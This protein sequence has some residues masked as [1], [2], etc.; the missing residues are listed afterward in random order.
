MLKGPKYLF[1][2]VK[3]RI[4]GSSNLTGVDCIINATIV[5]WDIKLLA[6]WLEVSYMQQ[7]GIVYSQT[8]CAFQVFTSVIYVKSRI[9]LVINYVNLIEF[10]I[11]TI[12]L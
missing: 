6:L 3:A 8:L 4:I 5:T 2:L 7:D 1:E 10:V 12:V 9:A 11:N